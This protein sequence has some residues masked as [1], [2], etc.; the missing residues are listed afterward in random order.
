MTEELRSLLVWTVVFLA[1][2]L[3]AHFGL[4]P[5][6]TLSRTVWNGEAWWPPVTAFVLAF[7]LVLL[8]HLELHWS[9]RWLVLTALAGAALVA[10]HLL[11]RWPA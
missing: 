11:E 9:A 6:F 7:T 8:G 4:V 5:W 3:P 10:S 2:E 1:F